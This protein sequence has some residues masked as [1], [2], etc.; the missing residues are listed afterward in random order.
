MSDKE[1]IHRWLT[2]A[3]LEQMVH[4]SVGTAVELAVRAIL[5]LDPHVYDENTVRAAAKVVRDLMQ[6]SKA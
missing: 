4:K 3:E 2:E 5:S 6:G 1:V